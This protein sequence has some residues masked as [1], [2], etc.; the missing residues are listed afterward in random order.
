MRRATWWVNRTWGRGP[1]LAVF[2]LLIVVGMPLSLISASHRTGALPSPWTVVFGAPVLGSL[3]WITARF[4]AQWYAKGLLAVVAV[5]LMS[6]T[7]ALRRRRRAQA[8]LDVVSA[9]TPKAYSNFSRQEV[10]ATQPL[11]NVAEGGEFA[12]TAVWRRVL[13]MTDIR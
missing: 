3:M 10:K 13:L 12:R 9:P 11:V 6:I 5:P 7:N 8:R 2:V 4:D 1:V